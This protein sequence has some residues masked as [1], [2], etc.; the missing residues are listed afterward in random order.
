MKSGGAVSLGL[1]LLVAPRV[2][3]ADGAPCGGP[4]H[5]GIVLRGSGL[6]GVLEAKITSQ[7]RAALAGRGFELCAAERADGAVA[8]LD[9]S[10]GG[11]TG[12]SLSLSVRDEVTDKRV[13]RELDLR[14]IPDDGRAL[15]IAEAA[16]ELLRASWA[17]LL[18]PD[19]PRPKRDVPPE[20][21]R[22]LPA[23]QGDI[24]QPPLP[25]TAPHA[26]V[27]ELGLD[28]AFE[29]YGS[30]HTQVGPELSA[31]LFPFSRIGAV[32][33]L[34]IRSAASAASTSGTVDPSA[35]AGGLGWF[36]A[37]LPREGSVG[38]EGGAELFVTHV[39]YAA[40]AFP[41][42]RAQS[43]SGTAVHASVVARGWAVIARP[44]RATAGLA[45]GA[46]IHTVRAVANDTTIAAVSGVLLG[47]TLGLGGA[48]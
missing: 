31:G 7:L 12:V 21:T 28:A 16:D 46:P 44:L 5:P 22:T 13:S 3:R 20:V 48:W 19:A 25:A 45:L 43:E 4:G 27:V 24:D 26:P 11:G 1:L 15:V 40:T 6:D 14:G 10:N 30:G 37:A 2:A 36:V 38:L 34:G 18:V 41:G 42:A 9:V 29:H 33:R 35:V 23:L 47:A 39:H 8:E 17:E 32:A